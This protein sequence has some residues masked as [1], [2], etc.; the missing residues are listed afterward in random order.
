MEYA[1]SRNVDLVVL[2]RKG[3]TPTV[4]YF[5]RMTCTT[6]FLSHASDHCLHEIHCPVLVISPDTLRGESLAT[7]LEEGKRSNKKIC[8]ACDAQ[9][10]SKDMVRWAAKMLI[11]EGDSVTVICVSME[12]SSG[13]MDSNG[14]LSRSTE[15]SVAVRGHC[16]NP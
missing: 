9:E 6:C 8:L 5:T 2:G 15:Q 4:W 16:P 1:E 3:L 12:T 14:M 11:T 7:R 10:H 13:G